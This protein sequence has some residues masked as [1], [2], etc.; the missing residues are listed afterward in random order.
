[1]S[2]RV[3]AI[4]PLLGLLVGCGGTATR[5]TTPPRVVE[6]PAP[7]PATPPAPT[8]DPPEPPLVQG[9]PLPGTGW[10]VLGE[11]PAELLQELWARGWDTA[12]RLL[13]FRPVDAR[14]ADERLPAS[15]LTLAGLSPQELRVAIAEASLADAPAWFAGAAE[16][17][18]LVNTFTS[19]DASPREERAAALRRLVQQSYVTYR[20]GVLG[21]ALAEGSPAEPWVRAGAVLVDFCLD[22]HRP[23][24]ASATRERWGGFR[25]VLD[26]EPCVAA[27]GWR[28]QLRSARRLTPEQRR[29][30]LGGARVGDDAVVLRAPGPLQQGDRVVRIGRWELADATDLDFALARLEP[31]AR[32]WVAVARGRGRHRYRFRAPAPPEDAAPLLRF[33]IVVAGAPSDPGDHVLGS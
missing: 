23:E 3:F 26:I 7:L 16:Y 29:R 1:M 9:E 8:P 12:P 20:A 31:R 25:G 13:D 27:M 24:D 32:F 15:T 5:R 14:I 22:T 18:V 28:R 17:R 2:G 10:S 11:A 6:R 19:P 33:E 30:Y 21:R 4:V